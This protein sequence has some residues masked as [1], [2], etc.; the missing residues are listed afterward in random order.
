MPRESGIRL[1]HLVSVFVLGEGSSPLPY[2]RNISYAHTLL[3]H[4][5]VGDDGKCASVFVDMSDTE[6]GRQPYYTVTLIDPISGGRV[7]NV[8]QSKSYALAICRAF[9]LAHEITDGE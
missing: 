4:W 7:E 8:G 5:C 1:D 3:D 6:E 9:I 2:S